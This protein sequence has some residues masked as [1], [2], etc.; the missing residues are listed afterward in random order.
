MNRTF[1]ITV[2]T[3]SL[4]VFF[5]ISGCS[6]P[7]PKPKITAQEQAQQ[8]T[9]WGQEVW[10]RFK[11]DLKIKKDDVVQKY[12]DGIALRLIQHHGE[13]KYTKPQTYLF[14]STEDQH[15]FLTLGAGI[16]GTWLCVDVELLKS[17]RYENEI[18]AVLA[19]QMG[20]LSN[21]LLAKK[22][23]VGFFYESPDQWKKELDQQLAKRAWFGSNGVFS[24]TQ[25]ELINA[26]KPAVEMLY[27]SG[28]DPRGLTELWKKQE[29]LT[30]TK[31][32]G[33][34]E[35]TRSELS[36]YVPLRNP[37]VR[38]PEFVALQRRI[39]KL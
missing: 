14:Q 27:Q 17:L 32:V 34:L 22:L 7:K 12:L 10:H 20:M 36:L 31:L 30:D 1:S 13:L 2:M 33:Y 18:A 37:V 25:D 38:T 8:D 39:K 5:A 21:K 3:C 35:K 24:F 9:R 28:Y 19:M 16:P 11:P 29:E 23:N 15:G 6:V 26:I 4:F